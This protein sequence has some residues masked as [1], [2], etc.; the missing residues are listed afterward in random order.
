MRLELG[1][2]LTLVSIPK[3]AEANSAEDYEAYEDH[4][5]RAANHVD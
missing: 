1:H 3:G 2:S 4:S 5:R